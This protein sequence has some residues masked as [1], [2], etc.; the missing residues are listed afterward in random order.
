[1]RI[2]V[3][4]IFPAMFDAISAY[5]VTGRAVEK[6]LLTLQHCN[7]RDYADPQDNYQSV[8]DR[9]YGGGPGMVMKVDPLRKAL[10]QAKA[11]VA[12]GSGVKPRC[13]YLS[14]QGKKLDQQGVEKIAAYQSLVLLAGR[15]EGVDER[16][17]DTEIDE[18]W[19]I[20][21]Y[22]ISG[23]E[24]AAMVLIDAVTRLLPG[25]LGHEG[26]AQVDSFVNGLLDYPHY[27]RPKD[28]NKAG[29]ANPLEKLKVPE[30]LLS[31]HHENV[32]RWR[33]KQ[34]LGRTWER[35]PDLLQGRLFTEEEETLLAEYI[36]EQNC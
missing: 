3:V 28:L 36:R 2:G 9:P 27:T 1:M 4:S 8:D 12:G 33:L 25:A 18:E 34:S 17:I 16:L 15:Y 10:A 30:V 29:D 31:G 35:R 20:G 24:L 32:R 5:G 22:V 19:S 7:P 13:I 11:S 23:G 14:P 26:S 6:G 21:D